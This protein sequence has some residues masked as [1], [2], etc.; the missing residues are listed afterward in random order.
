[1]NDNI[2]VLIQITGNTQILF[3]RDPSLGR[4]RV[5]GSIMLAA[6]HD[7]NNACWS[8]NGIGSLSATEFGD[9]MTE[10]SVLLNSASA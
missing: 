1:M 2:S 8:V 7:E 4:R 10:A 3:W 6:R 5:T 9:M